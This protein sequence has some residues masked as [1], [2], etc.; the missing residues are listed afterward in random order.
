[1]TEC[2]IQY[3]SSSVKSIV[4]KLEYRD[5]ASIEIVGM[6]HNN[7]VPYSVDSVEFMIN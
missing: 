6:T 3:I 2:R 4:L 1:M 7:T 5:K